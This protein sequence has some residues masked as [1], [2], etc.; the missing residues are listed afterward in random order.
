[1]DAGHLVL[2]GSG[3]GGGQLA[4]RCGPR[5][6][7]GLRVAHLLLLLLQLRLLLLLLPHLLLLLHLHLQLLLLQLLMPLRGGL[8]DLHLEGLLE[9]R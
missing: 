7:L 5:W 8:L 4:G 2:V 1:M 9:V 6:Q 3:A